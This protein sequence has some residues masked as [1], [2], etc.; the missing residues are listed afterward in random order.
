MLSLK[1]ILLI[2]KKAKTVLTAENLD[3]LQGGSMKNLDNDSMSEFSYLTT[4]SEIAPQ[5]N[6]LD[7]RI[8]NI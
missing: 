8:S 2:N 6:I 3:K 4:E 1:R 7:L 5:E